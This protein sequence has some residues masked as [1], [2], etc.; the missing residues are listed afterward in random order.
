M[1]TF[2]QDNR[3]DKVNLSIGLYYNE[4]A[5]IPRLEQWDEVIEVLT[6]RDLI[7]FLDIAYQDFGTTLEFGVYLISSG[8]VCVADLN[9]GNIA[10]VASAFS[11][12]Q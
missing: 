7:L 6:Y 5:I 4:Q 11:G 3:A 12:V 8:R 9:H 2:H 10:R 1:D